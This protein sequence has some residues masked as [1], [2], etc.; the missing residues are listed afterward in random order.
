MT[1]DDR[2][3]YVD[4]TATRY[5]TGHFL[6]THDDGVG[7]DGRLFAYVLNLT[8]VWRPDWAGC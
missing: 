7:D 4:A 3:V 2:I 6:N 8:P 1:G 5:R